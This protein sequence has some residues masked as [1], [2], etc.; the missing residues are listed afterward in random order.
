MGFVKVLAWLNG[1]TG[2]RSSCEG[3][4]QAVE[5]LPVPLQSRVPKK[6]FVLLGNKPTGHG[7]TMK[8]PEEEPK[9]GF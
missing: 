3:S 1:W 9:V 2:W 5:T 7:W 6:R 8:T 4:V